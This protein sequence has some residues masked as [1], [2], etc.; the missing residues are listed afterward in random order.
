MKVVLANIDYR[1]HMTDEGNQLQEGL[2]SVGW[3]L[4]GR[5]YDGDETDVVRILNNHQPGIVFVQDKRDWDPSSVGAFR[6]D[7]GFQGVE[8]LQ[9]V[10]NPPFRVT[11]LKDAATRRLYQRA[12]IEEE[13]NADAIVV[14]YDKEKVRELNPWIDRPMIR[15]YHTI[16]GDYARALDLRGTRKRALVSGACSKEAYPMRVM[17]KHWAKE[18]GLDV[19]PHPKHCNRGTRTPRYL[20]TLSRYLVHVATASRYG[21]ALRKIIESVAVGCTP[22]TDLP[23]SDVLPEIDGALVRVQPPYDVPDVER[24]IEHALGTWDMGERLAYARKAQ[25]YYD[26]RAMGERL[27]SAIEGLMRSIG[28][29]EKR[30]ASCAFAP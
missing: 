1:K 30:E 22:V 6:K 17:A 15:T 12:F 18:L 5:G 25:E 7:V 26:F 4:C 14:Y 20:Q 24:A 16:D 2:H 13:V 27:D 8:C 10:K 19:L 23:A 3:V 11:V 21:F 28:P 29:D 9:T